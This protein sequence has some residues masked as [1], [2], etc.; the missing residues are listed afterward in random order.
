VEEVDFLH[1]ADDLKPFP[2]TPRA[3]K[4]INGSDFLSFVVT[5]QPVVARNLCSIEDV[6]EVHR[7]L[8]TLLGEE[9]AYVDGIYFCPRHPDRGYPEENPLFKIDCRCRKP[10]TGMIEAAGRDYPS[11]CPNPGS[12][13]TGPWTSRR[14]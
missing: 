6:R 12:S 10:K 5:N 9:G 4:T 13:A 14:A 2:F 3:I 8:E 11:I 7:K 1:C